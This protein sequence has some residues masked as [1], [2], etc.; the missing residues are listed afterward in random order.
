MNNLMKRVTVCKLLGHDWA[1]SPYPRQ[2]N[3]D[4]TGEFLRCLRCR[5]ENHH[6]G[7]VARGVSPLYH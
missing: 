2:A 7:T 1:K 3:G 6:A 4:G 5:K